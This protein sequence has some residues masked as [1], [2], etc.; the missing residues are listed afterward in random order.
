[1]S[2]LIVL[3]LSVSSREYPE[4]PYTLFQRADSAVSGVER[5]SY[6]FSFRGTG[7]LGN[8]IPVLLGKASLS[9]GEESLHPL[10]V[11][12]FLD[13]EAAGVIDEF[14]VPSTYIATDDTLYR[15]DHSRRT[16]YAG[17]ATPEASVLFN[18]P[19]ASVMMEYVLEN[20]FSDEIAADSIAVLRTDSAGGVPC[21]VLHVYYHMGENTEAVWY[22]GMED[23]LPR[24]VER[25]GYYGNRGT[26]GGQLLEITDI[27]FTFP[28]D[29]RDAV[30]AVYTRETGFGL[31][32]PGDS[33]EAVFL[34]GTD[35]FTRR[36]GFPGDKPV[37][38]FFFSSWDRAS[39]AAIG[40]IN[41]MNDHLGQHID[42][43]GISIWENND[44]LFRLGAL[45]TG[46]PLL[47]Y[48]SDTAG[49]YGIQTVPTA[50]LI[51]SDGIVYHT[52]QGA[53][54]ITGGELEA[55]VR[56]LLEM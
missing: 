4:D 34:A 43:Y 3:L 39:M 49:D 51:N 38:L 52:S 10:M 28:P 18:F 2:L 14:T 22:I 40:T 21:H 31:A 29:P 17:A 42:I 36:V 6:S 24:A 33:A 25:M 30:P 20:P 32:A 46:F 12:D 26:P 53:E 11:L 15:V 23:L 19:P 5:V 45:E 7:S 13:I 48:G 16:V 47:I 27:E 41:A 8:I 9:P 50:V 37:L 55:P 44:P 56:S 1:M 54:E 35:G